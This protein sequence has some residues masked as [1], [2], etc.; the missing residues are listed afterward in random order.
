M[1]DFD[2]HHDVYPAD[3]RSKKAKP[4]HSPYRT[5]GRNRSRK[6]K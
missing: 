3:K 2:P 4:S 1:S 5:G 6:I